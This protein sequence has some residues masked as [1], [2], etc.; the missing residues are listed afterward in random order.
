MKLILLIQFE[1]KKK[2]YS[3]IRHRFD[4]KKISGDLVLFKVIE[5]TPLIEI[6]PFDCNTNLINVKKCYQL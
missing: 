6:T 1:V 5:F 4:M 3:T 2:S